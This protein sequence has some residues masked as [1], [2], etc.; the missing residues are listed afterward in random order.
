MQYD[1]G[2]GNVL[3]EVKLADSFFGEGVTVFNDTL[4][5]LTWQEETVFV[6][7]AKDFK[8]IK[9]L[10]IN[11]EGWGLT[12]DGGQ[13]IASNGSSNLYFY[14]PSTFR[15]LRELAVTEN[16]SPVL[17]INELE[18]VNGFVYANQWQLN[19]ILK[20]N[21]SNGEVVAKLDLTD[22]VRRTNTDPNN[23]LNGIAFNKNTNKF[24]VTGKNWPVLYE[25]QF[26]R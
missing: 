23:H 12:N 11:G 6:Y 8:K 24:Y 20:I 5:Q 7:S 17:N 21:P 26:D 13:L 19:Y 16:G 10:K 4:Y 15:L 25:I 1:P 18:Y 2:T 14:E 9:E 22:L 3:K